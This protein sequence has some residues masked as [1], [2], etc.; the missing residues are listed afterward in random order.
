[1]GNKT[2][3]RCFSYLL[4]CAAS[5]A[6]DK[7]PILA[8]CLK[9]DR[10]TAAEAFLPAAVLYIDG[11]AYELYIHGQMCGRN[12]LYRVDKLPLQAYEGP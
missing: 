8:G 1:M 10:G 7:I 4:F 2:R 6:P 3:S 5:A 12:P 9:I 11:G